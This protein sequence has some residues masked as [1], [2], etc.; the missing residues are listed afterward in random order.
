MS[1]GF[2]SQ[3]ALD[4]ALPVA[5][6]RG[7]VKFFRQ[8]RGTSF[9]FL[10]LGA[11][12]SVLVSVRR[13]RCIQGTLAEIEADNAVILARI[14]ITRPPAGTTLEFWLWSPYGTL[15]FFRVEPPGLI[16]LDR[17]GSVFAV[18]APG[19]K[20]RFPVPI[21]GK[22]NLTGLV[23]KEK[24]PGK[25]ATPEVM[26]AAIQSDSNENPASAK[27]SGPANATPAAG[28][29]VPLLHDL[30]GAADQ[31]HESEP[32]ANGDVI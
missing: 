19:R 17:A 13:A 21:R 31:G 30:A 6:A 9:S 12:S 27:E 11:L 24:I 23:K 8:D 29:P 26:G 2:P 22:N 18:Q 16:E 4:A 7:E 25:P 15:R 1:R 20:R 14:R 3:K 10:I 32:A 5:L 28:N